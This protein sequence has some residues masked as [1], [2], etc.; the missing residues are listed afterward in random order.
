MPITSQS[1]SPSLPV[2]RLTGRFSI[3]LTSSHQWSS[4]LWLSSVNGVLGF[5]S[6]QQRLTVSVSITKLGRRGCAPSRSITDSRRLTCFGCY[7]MVWTKKWKWKIRD[8]VT[9]RVKVK[10]LTSFSQEPMSI[11]VAV[12]AD[13]SQLLSRTNGTLLALTFL[14]RK[15]L[16]HFKICLFN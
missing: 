4:W 10:E 2:L 7:C 5:T 8:S 15:L 12:V 14:Y 16:T 6:S 1:H 3:T 13:L 11:H 9:K